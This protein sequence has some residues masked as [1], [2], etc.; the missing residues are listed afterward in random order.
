[1]IA[2]I[3]VGLFAADWDKS[4]PTGGSGIFT[5]LM[6]IVGC[7]GV[8]HLQ[9]I[10][11]NHRAKVLAHQAHFVIAKP[12]DYPHTDANHILQIPEETA[13]Y[14]ASQVLSSS[15]DKKLSTIYRIGQGTLQSVDNH[16]YWIYGL[17][18]TGWR[19]S[20]KVANAEF[21]GFVTVDAENPNAHAALRQKDADG[22]SYHI[23]YYLGGYHWHKLERYLWSHGYRD[24]LVRGLTLEVDDSWRPYYTASLDKL[25]VGRNHP[26]PDKALVINPQ[27]GNITQ[28]KF[29]PTLDPNEEG[30]LPDWVDR[31]YTG[32]VVK[33]MLN[34]WGEWGQA[35]WS[36]NESS[37]NR[38]KVSGDPVLVYTKGGHPV[39]QAIM[40]SYS[41]DTS[42]S[43]LVLFDARDNEGRVYS[44][45]GLTLPSVPKHIIANY[46]QNQKNLVPVHMTLHKIYGRLT[47]VAPLIGPNADSSGTAGQ[48][49][50]LLP[51]DETNGEHLV[52]TTKDMSE[53]LAQYREMLANGDDN[54]GP[55]ENANTKSVDGTVANLSKVV[56]SGQTVVYFTLKGDTTHIYRAKLQPAG[57]ADQNLELPFIKTGSK[58]R[59][60]YLDTGSSRRDVRAYDDLGLSVASGG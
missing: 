20:N 56:E 53:A 52:F 40:T 19:N 38:Y 13:D 14:Q 41:K 27:T 58:L 34:W 3:I 22:N 44:I 7:Y 28:Y 59:L 29:G 54:S 39:W 46:G 17:E 10:G 47:W 16:L 32:D 30:N 18:P 48:G 1:V 6:V 50:A 23:K 60:T 2:G 8:I 12:G 45:P 42:A 9:W 26:V 43:Y 31:V 4:L 33:K 49:V 55:E 5:V 11:S 37:A 57:A 15:A 24:K 21:P 51:Y 25:T 36:L 35:K